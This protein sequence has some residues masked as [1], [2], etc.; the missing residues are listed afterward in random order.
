MDFSQHIR[1]KAANAANA[2]DADIW[3][4][5]ASLV[6]ERRIRWCCADGSWLVSVDHRHIATEKSFDDAIRAAKRCDLRVGDETS[7]KAF[8]RRRIGSPK[9]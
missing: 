7:R 1:Q 8:P 9:L 3:R 4:W 6:E 5:L 2:E